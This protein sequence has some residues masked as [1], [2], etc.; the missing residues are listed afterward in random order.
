MLT[1]PLFSNRFN[2]VCFQICNKAHDHF[3][4]ALHCGLTKMLNLSQSSDCVPIWIL[5]KGQN[6]SQ[7]ICYMEVLLHDDFKW[8]AH[9]GVAWGGGTE[10]HWDLLVCAVDM[11][12]HQNISSNISLPLDSG[13]LPPFKAKWFVK[14]TKKKVVTSE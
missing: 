10:A 6:F 8:L 3:F 11:D 7:C 13:D 1:D 9:L 5:R 2:Y 14:V 4:R 12:V